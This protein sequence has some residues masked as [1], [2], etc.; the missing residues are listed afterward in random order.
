M[1]SAMGKIMQ[2]SEDPDV[3]AAQEKLDKAME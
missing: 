1:M 3:Q 2:Y